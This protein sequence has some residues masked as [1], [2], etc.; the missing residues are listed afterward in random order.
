MILLHS[1]VLY[2]Y[3]SHEKSFAIQPLAF[4]Q[5]QCNS[6]QPSFHMNRDDNA[7]KNVLKSTVTTDTITH[8][9]RE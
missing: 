2:T 5:P 3:M 8:R 4:L 9:V 7:R 1:F 6:N